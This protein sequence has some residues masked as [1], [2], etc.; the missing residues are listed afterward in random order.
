[1]CALYE[2]ILMSHKTGMRVIN[3]LEKDE[4]LLLQKPVL[5]H[6]KQ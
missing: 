5:P 3:E 6:G 1:M 2:T 4:V